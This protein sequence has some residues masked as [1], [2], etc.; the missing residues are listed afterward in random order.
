MLTF[1]N[2]LLHLGRKV[3]VVYTGST[4]YQRTA[5]YKA[6]DITAALLSTILPVLQS[7]VW[8]KIASV[9][10]R[11]IWSNSCVFSS[12]LITVFPLNEVLNYFSDIYIYIYFSPLLILLLLLLLLPPPPPPP[13]PPYNHCVATV[14]TAI[15]TT[16]RSTAPVGINV[17]VDT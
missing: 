6:D 3:S 5:C 12:V 1:I 17:G 8:Q 15:A 11:S 2:M 16:T 14:T 7:S 4:F 13:P 10:N 9:V